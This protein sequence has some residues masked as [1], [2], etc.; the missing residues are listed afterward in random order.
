[1]NPLDASPDNIW[2]YRQNAPKLVARDLELLAG[3]EQRVTHYVLLA[4]GVYKW[5]AIRRDLIR[6]KNQW[7]DELT[8]LYRLQETTHRNSLEYHERKGRIKTLETCRKQ[9]R[10]LCHSERWRAP[11]NDREAQKFLESVNQ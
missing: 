5:L 1:M 6:L 2:S 11:D 4:R 7:R 8:A 3:V 10:E 9:V